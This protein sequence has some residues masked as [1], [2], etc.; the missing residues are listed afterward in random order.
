MLSETE[1][2]VSIDD[3]TKGSRSGGRGGLGLVP[4]EKLTGKEKVKKKVAEMEEERNIIHNDT[5][6]KVMQGVWTTWDHN[7]QIDSTWN[8]L[9]YG[10]SPALVSFMLNSIQ[11][12]LPSPDNLVRWGKTSIGQ[13][14]LCN[15]KTCTM[16]HILSDCRTSLNDGRYTW[17]HDNV[18]KIIADSAKKAV[19]DANKVLEIPESRSEYFIHFVKSGSGKKTKNSTILQGANDWQLISDTGEGKLVFPTCIYCTSLRPDLAI[20]SKEQ[21]VVIIIELTCP[22]EERMAISN[23]LKLTKYNAELVPGC[24]RNGWKVPLYAV[25]VGCRG[26]VSKSFSSIMRQIGLK[27]VKTLRNRCSTTVLRS[28]YN[29]WLHR[30]NKEF[31]KWRNPSLSAIKSTQLLSVAS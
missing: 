15:N 21:K 31:N 29:I 30:S 12:T 16:L 18:L 23:N 4:T 8:T 10:L 28:S 17:R 3:L 14:K 9:L 27:D 22:K 24:R 2:C 5:Y 1:W 13:C 26:F 6:S 11:M 25:E 19:E 20:F 7:M